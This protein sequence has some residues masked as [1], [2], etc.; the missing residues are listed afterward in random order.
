MKTFG[1]EDTM[2]QLEYNVVDWMEVISLYCLNHYM[3]VA[4]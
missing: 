3:Y 2:K 1:G 4:I